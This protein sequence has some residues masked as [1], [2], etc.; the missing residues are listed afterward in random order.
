MAEE[1]EVTKKWS[2]VW[3]VPLDEGEYTSF[4]NYFYDHYHKI[5][6]PRPDR[7]DVPQP[8]SPMKPAEFMFIHHLM[9]HEG[10]SPSLKTI[11]QEMGMSIQM[12]REYKKAIEGAG[13]L[14][15]TYRLH[16]TST[17]DL[18]DFILAMKA[19]EE[20]AIEEARVAEEE[21]QREIDERTRAMMG[22]WEPD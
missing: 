19:L 11:A 15:V 8:A 10:E 5:L 3:G 16:D 9:R 14:K 18:E 20:E 4:P 13:L 2:D 17:Y 21:K 1:T 7:G 6:L 22:K 12:V